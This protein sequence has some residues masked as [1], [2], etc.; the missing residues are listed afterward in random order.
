MRLIYTAVPDEK[1]PQLQAASQLPEG[2]ITPRTYVDQQYLHI[3]PSDINF[4]QDIHRFL[5]LCSECTT[6]SR[7]L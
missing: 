6:R 5:V 7:A 2:I 1:E 4:V 3:P